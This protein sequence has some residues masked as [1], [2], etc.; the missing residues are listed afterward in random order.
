MYWGFVDSLKGAVVLF[1][2]DKNINEKIYKQSPSRTEIHG[3][4]TVVMHGPQKHYNQLRYVV[5][6]LEANFWNLSTL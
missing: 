4:D 2:M 3:K 1:Y 5:W 6:F